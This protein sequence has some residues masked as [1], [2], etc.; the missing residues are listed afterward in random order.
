MKILSYDDTWADL[1]T[2][3][4]SNVSVL[5]VLARVFLLLLNAALYRQLAA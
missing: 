1:V 3:A 4:R 2:M 5:L